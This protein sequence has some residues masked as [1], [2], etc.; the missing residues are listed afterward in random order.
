MKNSLNKVLEDQSKIKFSSEQD[1]N[2]A[3]SANNGG[4]NGRDGSANS[5]EL[6][7]LRQKI[8]ILNKKTNGL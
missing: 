7:E 5:A 3:Q 6:S 8:A 4:K 2:N 1:K